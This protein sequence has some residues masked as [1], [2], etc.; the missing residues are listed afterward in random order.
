M[1][2]RRSQMVFFLP[3]AFCLMTLSHYL[4]N[5]WEPYAQH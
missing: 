2:S 5:R 3:Y 4:A 1:G